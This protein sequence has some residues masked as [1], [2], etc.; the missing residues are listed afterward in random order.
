MLSSPLVLL[1]SVVATAAKA[2]KASGSSNPSKSPTTPT[3]TAMGL[4]PR[5]AAPHRGGAYSA[6]ASTTSS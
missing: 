4:A 5:R 6:N 2:A 3:P 1:I